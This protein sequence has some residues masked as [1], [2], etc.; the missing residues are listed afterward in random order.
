MTD[1][2]VSSKLTLA[3]AEHHIRDLERQIEPF[4]NKEFWSY[5]VEKDTDGIT[6]I[7]KVRFY[8]RL[9]PEVLCILFDAA[10]NLRAALDQA[11]YAASVLSGK[12]EPKRTYFPFADSEF[13][14]ANVVA[15]RSK[16]L[17]LKLEALLCVQAIQTKRESHSLGSQ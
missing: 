9:P 16:D 5:V 13:E 12:V 10:N 3:R 14:L 7:H 15:R 6:N 8:R 1:P 17:P 11:G 4:I 2:F